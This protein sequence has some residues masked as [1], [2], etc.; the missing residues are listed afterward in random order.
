VNYYDSHDP[1][2]RE[3]ALIEAVSKLT[4]EV[5]RLQHALTALTE[6]VDETIPVYRKH[7]IGPG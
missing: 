6:K 7:Y 4:Q 2:K 3:M 1:R 5:G